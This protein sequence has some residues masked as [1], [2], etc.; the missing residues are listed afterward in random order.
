MIPTTLRSRTSILAILLVTCVGLI[1]NEMATARFSGL[2][3][4]QQVHVLRQDTLYSLV[5]HEIHLPLSCTRPQRRRLVDC[6][7]EDQPMKLDPSIMVI[8]FSPLAF[9][10]VRSR[11]KHYSPPQLITQAARQNFADG[12][13]L[14]LKRQL[15]NININYAAHIITLSKWS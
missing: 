11:A 13:E 12:S 5:V 4:R 10:N 1:P 7:N 15:L 9:I 6:N 14:R 3:S 2:Y 8:N